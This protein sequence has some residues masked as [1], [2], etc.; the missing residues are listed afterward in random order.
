MYMFI[1]LLQHSVSMSMQTY[2][3]SSTKYKTLATSV[4]NEI[5]THLDEYMAFFSSTP[6]NFKQQ[7]E[8]CFE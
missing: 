1:L 4:K 3:D 5:T 8:N 7:I 2:L 6:F